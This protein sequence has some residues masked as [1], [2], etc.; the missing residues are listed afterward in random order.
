MSKIK[1]DKQDTDIHIHIYYDEKDNSHVQHIPLSINGN[2]KT[3]EKSDMSTDRIIAGYASVIEIDSENQIIPKSTLEDGIQTLLSNAD[4][5]NLMITHNNIQIGKV[6]KEWGDLKTHVDDTGLF[7]VAKLRDDLEIANEV[8]KS[9]LDRELTGF[10]IAAEVLVDHDECDLEKCVTV[11]DKMNVFEI[12]ICS[13]PINQKS[14]F[15]VIS[16]SCDI[17]EIEQEPNMAKKKITKSED[18]KEEKSEDIVKEVP[19]TECSEEETKEET[20]TEIVEEKSEDTFD[21][22]TVLNSIVQEIEA[23]KGTLEALKAEPM[24]DEEEEEEEEEE[25]IVESKSEPEPVTEEK[26]EPELEEKSELTK[27]YFDSLKKSIDELVKGVASMQKLQDIQT[28]LKS[29]EDDIDALSK[30]IEFLEKSEKP[31]AKVDKVETAEDQIKEKGFKPTLV[32]D[33]IR[34]G[35]IYREMD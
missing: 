2:L 29:K 9:I 11:I 25:E 15:I 18:S 34:A 19:C 16:K 14:G 1:V 13:R 4:Y 23:I 3:I 10:S 28:L 8:W 7:I 17:C 24:D 30:R 33:P 35:T 5:A 31:K 22:K 12:S 27:E 21:V 20:S 26:S 32:R 6:L